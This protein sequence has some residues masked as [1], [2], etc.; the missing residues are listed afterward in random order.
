MSLTGSDRSHIM[1]VNF[2]RMELT[3][4]RVASAISRMLIETRE[5]KFYAR[6]MTVTICKILKTSKT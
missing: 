2:Y 1:I 3:V 5:R 4:S 6:L